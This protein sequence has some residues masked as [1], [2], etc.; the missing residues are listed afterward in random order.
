MTFVPY[1]DDSIKE[2]IDTPEEQRLVESIKSSKLEQLERIN[3]DAK[4]ECLIDPSFKGSKRYRLIGKSVARGI[5]ACRNR[6][7]RLVTYTGEPVTLVGMISAAMEGY[8]IGDEFARR[9]RG[10]R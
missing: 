10:E 7:E 5:Q 6:G 2:Y 8:I 4:T 9:W 1:F 3:E